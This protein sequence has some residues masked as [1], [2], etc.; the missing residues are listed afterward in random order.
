M[1]DSRI[2]R[3]IVKVP[4]TLKDFTHERKNLESRSLLTTNVLCRDKIFEV[5]HETKPIRARFPIE[6]DLEDQNIKRLRITPRGME[7]LYNLNRFNVATSRAKGECILV[8]NPKLFEPECRIPRQMKLANALC[9]YR[10]MAITI[11]FS[12]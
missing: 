9:H 10:Q 5:C 12:R 1:D 3:N 7:F 11:D 4:K 6:S 2:S 8:A